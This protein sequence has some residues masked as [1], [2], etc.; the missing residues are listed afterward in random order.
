MQGSRLSFPDMRRD[1]T[2]RMEPGPG[3]PAGQ[4]PYLEEAGWA[5]WL[6]ALQG[7]GLGWRPHPLLIRREG[8]SGQVS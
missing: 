4:N 8:F 2:C 6:G 5:L 1:L 7:A 3:A